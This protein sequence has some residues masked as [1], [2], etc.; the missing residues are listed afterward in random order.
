M[1]YEVMGDGWFGLADSNY[2]QDL[3]TYGIVKERAIAIRKTKTAQ[4]DVEFGTFN[5]K[6]KNFTLRKL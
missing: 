1:V 5:D 6:E 3:V 4:F 2:G